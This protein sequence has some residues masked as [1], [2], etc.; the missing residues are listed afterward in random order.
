MVSVVVGQPEDEIAHH[1]DA[2]PLDHPND[3]DDVV[4]IRHHE[5]ANVVLRHHRD[6]VHDTGVR[7]DA[8]HPA[9]FAFENRADLH[10]YPFCH[11]LKEPWEENSSRARFR[12]KGV[13]FRPRLDVPGTSAYKRPSDP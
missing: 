3:A 1:V 11:R 6:G 2:G 9:A 10:S 12:P 7:G 13:S 8:T 4:A 5:G